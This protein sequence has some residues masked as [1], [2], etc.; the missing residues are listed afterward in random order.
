M[1]ERIEDNYG[2]SG[3]KLIE[4]IKETEKKMKHDLI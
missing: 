4:K 2:S 3:D 1:I